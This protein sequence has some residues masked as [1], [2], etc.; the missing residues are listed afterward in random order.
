MPMKDFIIKRFS[1][2]KWVHRLL[3]RMGYQLVMIGA[4]FQDVP[5]AHKRIFQEVKPFT[6]T[7][8]SNVY[9]LLQSLEHLKRHNVSG[10]VVECGVWRGGMMMAAVKGMQLIGE[11]SREVYL[12][13]TFEG[14][15]EPGDQ[16]DDKAKS[17]YREYKRADGTSDWC[18]GALEEVRANIESCGPHPQKV[19][20]VKGKVEETIPGVLPREIALLRLDT[21]WYE[22]TRHEFLHLFPLVSRGGIVIIDDYGAWQGSRK[23]TDEYLAQNRLAYF[24]HRIDSCSRLF[25][26]T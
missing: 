5:E 22:S 11:K 8:E 16:D 23:A 4:E 19:H 20:Y 25:V 1:H 17:L 9:T 21:D 7:S 26:K 6:M 24:L 3:G 10:S 15:S 18:R 14:M 12:Y 13:D 2:I